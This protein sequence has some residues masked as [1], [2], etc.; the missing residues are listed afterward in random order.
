MSDIKPETRNPSLRLFALRCAVHVD[1]LRH[2]PADYLWSIWWHITGKK[3]R[4]RLQLAPLLGASSRAYDL[5]RAQRLSDTQNKAAAED[6]GPNL[7]AII[8]DGDKVELTLS[9]CQSEG[10]AASV[11]SAP[12]DLAELALRN[13]EWA[14][15]LFAGDTLAKGA[16]AQYRAATMASSANTHVIYA[17]DDLIDSAGRLTKPHLKPSWNG[18]LFEHFDFLT[19]SALIRSSML[20]DLAHL[21]QNWAEKLTHRAIAETAKSAGEPVHI[22]CVLHH[23]RARL[24]S[25]PLQTLADGKEPLPSISV[26]IPTRNR[27]DLL[28][29]CLEGLRRTT[30]CGHLDILVID[31]GSDDEETL[32]YLSGLDTG[33][34][35]V[36]RDDGPFN[37]AALNNRAVESTRG[38]LLCFLNNDIEVRDPNWLRVMATQALRED[39]GAVGARLLYP[40]GRIQHAGVV[41]GIGGA[42]AHAHRRIAP[43]EEGYFHRHSLPQFVSAVTAACLVVSRRKFL[44][45]GG[46]D[47]RNFAVSFNDVDL[48]LRLAQ[49][50][51]NSLYEPRATLIHHESVS[52]GLDRDVKGAARQAQEVAALQSKWQTG[53]ASADNMAKGVDPYHHPG[54]SRLSELFV[55]DL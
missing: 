16:H 55:L 31:N 7:R 3:L 26:I 45:V 24:P 9:S 51:W 21:D 32:D 27:V 53:L 19:G 8:N 2:S 52:R 15:P 46:F 23:R 13:D 47:E 30:Y 41:L 48:C 10:L 6:K 33:V 4:A 1:A 28:R 42:A 37:F 12:H 25:K 14:L 50:G 38:E 17:D 40:D 35:R 22:P 34:A 43:N 5:W 20:P 39:V 36:L 18:E 29:E 44:A 49:Q 11:I 54:L